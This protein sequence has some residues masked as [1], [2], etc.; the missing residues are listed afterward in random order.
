MNIQC[1]GKLERNEKTNLFFEGNTATLDCNVA[2]PLEIQHDLVHER[3]YS[4]YEVIQGSYEGETIVAKGT[5]GLLIKNPVW[6]NC[7][8]VKIIPDN[9]VL[10]TELASR[11][12]PVGT[13]ILIKRQ[14]QASK[15]GNL[16]LPE[17]CL[18]MKDIAR[19]LEVGPDVTEVLPG[20]ELLAYSR[21]TLG[22]LTLP[23]EVGRQYD[24]QEGETLAFIDISDVLVVNEIIES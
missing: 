4:M 23:E 14:K 1:I 12:I 10:A 15:H 19:V 11:L 6:V 3:F 8:E 24:L 21:H 13:K 20:D 22:D 5:A 7:K 2:I 17:S 16:W 18:G 9:D